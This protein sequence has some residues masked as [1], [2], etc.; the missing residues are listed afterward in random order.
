MNYY[1]INYLKTLSQSI[2]KKGFLFI[3]GVNIL[4][5]LMQFVISIMF[6]RILGKADYGA[7]SYAQNIF[8][9]AMLFSGFGMIS[10]ILQ[11]CSSSKSEHEKLSYFKYGLKNGIIANVFISIILIFISQFIKLPIERSNY[12][13]LLFAT[14]P[15]F[16]FLYQGIN[17]FIRSLLKNNIYFLISLSFMIS[18]FLLAFFGIIHFGINGAVLSRSIAF[19][20]SV[21]FGLFLIKPYFIKILHLKD[22]KISMKNIKQFSFIAMLTN[23]ISAILYLIDIFLIGLIIKDSGI[24]AEYKTATLIPFSLN[25]IPQSFIVFSYPY[26]AK[27]SHN[28]KWV[29]LQYFRLLKYLFFINIL[30]AIVLILFAPYVVKLLFGI[31]YIKIVP[32]FRILLIGFIFSGSFR[33]PAGNILASLKKVNINLINAIIAGILNI[34]LDVFLIYKFGSIGAAFSTLSIFIISSLISNIYLIKY[35]KNK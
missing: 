28:L 31:K 27:N 17:T 13:L 18:Y 8:G 19:I 11:F 15:V 2:I 35:V 12:V 26:F 32:I 5:K 4:S 3:F 10:G 34:F 6:V 33:I 24:L 30:I 7:L 25:I 1:N 29:K 16:S 21:I 14:I 20:F 22:N 9:I 23:A